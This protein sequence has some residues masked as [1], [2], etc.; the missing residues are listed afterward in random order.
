MKISGQEGRTNSPR[1][2]GTKTEPSSLK[3]RNFDFSQFSCFHTS[4]ISIIL[5]FDAT[6]PRAREFSGLGL[7]KLAFWGSNSKKIVL[8]R[9]FSGLG[10]RA[11]KK[12]N[13]FL[14]CV[15]VHFCSFSTRKYPFLSGQKVFHS[16]TKASSLK[17][18]KK[19]MFF[20]S[21][22]FFWFPFF[23]KLC[24]LAPSEYPP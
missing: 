16:K 4:A 13:I 2:L 20:E 23:A 8:T 22:E 7:R 17:I 14:Y 3:I 9:C 24:A 6:G 11:L 5:K 21:P 18:D 10:P 15:L 1:V 19:C 12:M